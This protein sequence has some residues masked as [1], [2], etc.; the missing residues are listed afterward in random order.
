MP[1]L[2]EVEA[3]AQFLRDHAVGA[4][5]GRVDVAA[6]SV[7]KTFDPPI[8][9]LQGRNV[10]GADRFGKHLALDCDGL[11][12]IAHL[13]RGGWLRWIDN[14][15]SAPPKPGK[16][17]LAVRVH[18]F[19]PDGETPAFDLTEAGTK[20][21]LAVWVVTDP[22]L[23]PG[24]ARLGPDALEVTRPQFGEILAGTTSRIKTALVDQSLLA[25]IGNAYSDEIL[26]A[27]RL[28]PFATTSKLAP[29]EVDRLYDAMRAELSDAVER[30]VGQEAARLKGEKR[31]G[32]TVHA[33]TG[34]PCPV[35]GDTVREVAYA[36]RSFQYCPTCQTG[37]RILADRRMSRLL[38]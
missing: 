19:T 17:P 27:A 12:L 31:A 2:P 5:V 32:M 9:S 1:E 10:T 7:L 35:C 33:R 28:S 26:H 8:T 3:L 6:L 14:P 34:M 16:G 15:G 36:E 18:F 11:W 20:K 23:V 25:G 24:I 37:G 13:S 30:S 29:D 22:L 4:V 21:R 38:K